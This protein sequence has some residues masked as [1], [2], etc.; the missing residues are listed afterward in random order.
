MFSLQT[1]ISF[2]SGVLN[3]KFFLYFLKR[4]LKFSLNF[5][6]EAWDKFKGLLVLN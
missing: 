2:I 3:F 4:R 1:I 6:V 5:R